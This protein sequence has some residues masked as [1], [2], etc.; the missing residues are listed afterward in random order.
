MTFG[1]HTVQAY[2]LPLH[3]QKEVYGWP[4]TLTLTLLIL[5]MV[6]YC[7]ICVQITKRQVD[8]FVPGRQVPSCQLDAKWTGQQQPVELV[9]TVELLGAK[10][11]YNFFFIRIPPPQGCVES[12][13][14]I[15][16]HKC[17]GTCV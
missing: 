15:V 13:L 11:P 12:L 5:I 7:M 6:V 17:F 3:L 14:H 8:Q 16:M 4:T 2:F 10:A 1:S 9:H